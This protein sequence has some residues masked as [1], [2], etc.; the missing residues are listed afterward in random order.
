MQTAKYRK[1]ERVIYVGHN[2]ERKGKRFTVASSRWDKYMKTF[3]YS[4]TDSNGKTTGQVIS[5][6]NLASL[7]G[8]AMTKFKPGDSVR[9]IGHHL[10]S[11]IGLALVI[12]SCVAPQSSNHRP[13]YGLRLPNG[14][15]WMG[16]VAE[17]L[18]MLIEPAVSYVKGDKV[19]S[20]EAEGTF[21]VLCVIGEHANVFGPLESDHPIQY[22]LHTKS[23]KPVSTSTDSVIAETRQKFPI[24]AG[25]YVGDD[26]ET[27]WVI[28]EFLPETREYRM[29]MF[30]HKASAHDGFARE[31]DLVLAVERS[32][33]MYAEGD[34][35][36]PVTQ[37]NQM[38]KVTSQ[39]LWTVHAE[40]E[41]GLKAS[42]STCQ[43]RHATREE[44]EA[45]HLKKNPVGSCGGTSGR[46]T[47]HDALWDAVAMLTDAVCMTPSQN[48]IRAK[49]MERL[50]DIL[51]ENY[52]K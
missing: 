23:L 24:D 33:I 32:P 8:E 49:R 18:L 48:P 26:K 9:Y 30:T 40:T 37:P 36:V 15:K 5:E 44:V 43:V 12:D 3:Y 31:S 25:V 50:V 29:T 34:M 21:E 28:K 46:D 4:L 22:I 7:K 35:I 27:M 14:S 13:M 6:K 42:Y 1:G 41:G 38:M 17:E 51:S 19:T 45:W 47:S 2:R 11:L 39:H 10:Y 52:R 20:S 16:L